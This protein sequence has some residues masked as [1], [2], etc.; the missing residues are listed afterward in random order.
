MAFKSVF[1]AHVPDA[2]PV[3]HKCEVET[4]LYKLYVR[5]VKNQE[6]AVEVC[7]NLAVDEGIHS[8]LLC[9]GFTHEQIAEISKEVG[10]NVGVSV[11]RGDGNS[12]RIAVEAMKKAGWFE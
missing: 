7:K 5:L 2:D 10:E 8:I 3:E 4:S 12:S 9:P 1:I 6:E 11:A